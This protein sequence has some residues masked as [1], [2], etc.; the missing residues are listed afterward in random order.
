MRGWRAWHHYIALVMMA[1]LLMLE[2]KLASQQSHPLLS[3]SYIEVLLAP[4]LPRRDIAVE[5]VIPQM[6]VRHEARRK[7]IE[8]AAVELI[9]S[10][11]SFRARLN[12]AGLE[13][14]REPRVP[15]A[16]R[17]TQNPTGAG[18]QSCGVNEAPRSSPSSCLDYIRQR[19]A[20]A[21]V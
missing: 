7:A 15:V 18:R 19:S 12:R 9:G 14:P 5:E 6:E 11:H 13:G 21:S 8:S 1:M 10:L 4:F 3:C 17:R 2:G 16:P 20:E